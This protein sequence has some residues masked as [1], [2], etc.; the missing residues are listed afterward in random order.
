MEKMAI[1]GSDQYQSNNR[2]L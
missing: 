1:A 2:L